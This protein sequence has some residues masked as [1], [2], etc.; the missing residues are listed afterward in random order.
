MKII[1]LYEASKKSETCEYCKN[2]ATH[3]FIWADGRAYVP[4]C[5]EHEDNATREIE[6]NGDWA[7]IIGARP[8]A[9]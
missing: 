4:I 6:K 8:Y 1:E 9:N 7:E 3:K 2:E 5:E